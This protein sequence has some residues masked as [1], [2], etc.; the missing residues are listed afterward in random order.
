VHEILITAIVNMSGTFAFCVV[1]FFIALA[2]VII[3]LAL[4]RREP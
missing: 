3:T 2:A 4:N 1:V